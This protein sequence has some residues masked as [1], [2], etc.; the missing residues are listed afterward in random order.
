MGPCSKCG[1]QSVVAANGGLCLGCQLHLPPKRTR[2]MPR[3]RC[4]QAGFH[5]GHRWDAPSGD[6]RNRAVWCVG[7]K[8][9]S[10][11]EVEEYLK[12]PWQIDQVEDFLAS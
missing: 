8:F 4:D 7:G 6:G 12:L 2:Q 5:H 3:R 1:T 10:I 9:A 11:E